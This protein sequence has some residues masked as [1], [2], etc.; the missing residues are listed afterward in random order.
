MNLLSKHTLKF[1]LEA[2]KGARQIRSHKNKV[3][4]SNAKGKSLFGKKDNPFAFLSNT[5]YPDK[6]LK[7]SQ[8]YQTATPF[9]I[10]IETP[11]KIYEITLRPI[12]KSV[13]IIAEDISDKIQ[14]QNL[15]N[16]QY[17][18][19]EDAFDQAEFGAYLIQNDGRFLFANALSLAFDITAT[20]KKRKYP[21]LLGG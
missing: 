17:N 16:E 12:K 7:L 21:T 11:T 20:N 2:E 15:L 9:S 18:L 14:I 5:L 8:A 3:I 19:F 10:Q 6:L 4:V 13:M 1:L